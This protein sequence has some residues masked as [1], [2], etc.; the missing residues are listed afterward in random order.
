MTERR[1]QESILQVMDK[2]GRIVEKI[3][4]YFCVLL[5]ASMTVVVL[6]GVLF[7]YVMSSPFEW[8]EEIARFLMLCICFMA[9]N[10]AMRRKEHIA[11]TSAIDKLPPGLSK[12]LGYIV[13]IQIAFFLI[14]L[15][16]Q[17]YLMSMRTLMTASTFNISMKWIYMFVP[18][19]ALLTL[20]QLLILT[21]KKIF[22][23]FK[24]V[25]DET[26]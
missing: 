11:I 3:S 19:G 23:D 26:G 12:F 1:P 22:N 6:V 17:G 4:G 18:L 9:M 5:F 10:M 20:I 13:D 2:A 8:T 16:K 21:T 24:L 15:I 14:L 7:R 25:T